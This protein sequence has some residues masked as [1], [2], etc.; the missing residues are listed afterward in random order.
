MGTVLQRYLESYI[1]ERRQRSKKFA[2]GMKRRKRESERIKKRLTDYFRK[3]R[4][5]NFTDAT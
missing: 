1:S 5:P 3:H 2:E 4:V